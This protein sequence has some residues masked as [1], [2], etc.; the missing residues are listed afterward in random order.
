MKLLEFTKKIPARL[1]WNLSWLT[2]VEFI[3]IAAIQFMLKYAD[4]QLFVEGGWIENLQLVILGSALIIALRSPKDKALFTALSLVIVLMLMRETNLGRSYF[5]EKYLSPDEICRWKKMKY[6]FIV[7][8][9]RD[10]YVVYILYYI[11]SKKVYQTIWQYILHAPVFVWDSL[12]LIGA[13]VAATLAEFPFIDNE[14]LEES[15]EMLMY[16]A[17]TSLVWKYSRRT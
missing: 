9:L 1:Q 6:G 7:E 4:T 11:W 15:C 2:V 14:I 12:V 8:P 10:L 5:C 13:A 16:I 3:Y 17:F